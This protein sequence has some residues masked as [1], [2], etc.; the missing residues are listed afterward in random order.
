MSDIALGIV[1]G[2]WAG[3]SIAFLGGLIGYSLRP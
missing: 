2:L 1:I 3:L